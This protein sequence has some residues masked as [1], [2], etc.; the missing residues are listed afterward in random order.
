MSDSYQP[1]PRTG[2]RRSSAARSLKGI[3]I[4]E[5]E[6]LYAEEERSWALASGLLSLIEPFRASALAA[7]QAKRRPIERES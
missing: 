7:E 4:A 3:A 6:S 2:L 1:R 5:D